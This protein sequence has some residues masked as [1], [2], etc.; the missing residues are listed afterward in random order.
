[1]TIEEAFGL[2][3]HN[4]HTHDRHGEVVQHLADEPNAPTNDDECG[5]TAPVGAE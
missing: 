5:A 4:Q 1:M 3:P 2:A